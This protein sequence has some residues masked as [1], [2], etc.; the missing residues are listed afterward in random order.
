VASP[1]TLGPALLYILEKP[2]PGLRPGA[3]VQGTLTLEEKSSAW[4]IPES[5]LLRADGKTF[6]YRE[7]GEADPRHARC[8]VKLLQRTE[9]HEVDGWLVSGSLKAGDKVVS[10]GAFTLLARETLGSEDGAE[11]DKEKEKAETKTKSTEPTK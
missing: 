6:V 4:F 5:A 8:P 3:A 11:T 2:Q 7:T 1:L 10:Q 9:R